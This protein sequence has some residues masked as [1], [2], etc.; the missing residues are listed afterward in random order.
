ME[1]REK[2]R[3]ESSQ[4]MEVEGDTHPAEGIAAEAGRDKAEERE[5]AEAE[6]WQ[7]DGAGGHKRSFL[8]S[9]SVS[10]VVTQ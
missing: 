5:E 7:G 9:C 8:V 4:G 1:T 2:T 6:G 3:G 10:V